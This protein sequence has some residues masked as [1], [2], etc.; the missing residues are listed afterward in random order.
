[1][2]FVLYLT[3]V[4]AVGKTSLAI[5]LERRVGAVR[6]SYGDILTQTLSAKVD[7]Q[8]QLRER[9][10]DVISARDVIETDQLVAASILRASAASDV[11]VDSHALTAETYGLR[12]VPYSATGLLAMGFTHIVC[13]TAPPEIVRNRIDRQ[14]DGR[15]G[16]DEW[17][18][19]SHAAL[20]AGLALSYAH[21]LGVPF[22][23]LRSDRDLAEVVDDV[24]AFVRQESAT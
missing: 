11:V 6:L 20:Q 8:R 12:A 19:L 18:M 10:A 24:V 1:V 4:P 17:D 2:T 14:A 22:A 5:A 21:T 23:F 7:N 13:L 9:S 16:Q 15:R 3:G